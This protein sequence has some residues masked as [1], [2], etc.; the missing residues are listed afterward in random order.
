M[1]ATAAAEAAAA[2]VASLSDSIATAKAAMADFAWP[3]GPLFK[4]AYER[5]EKA[6]REMQSAHVYYPQVWP[7]PEPGSR[8]RRLAAVN[9]ECEA[10]S[11]AVAEMEAASAAADAPIRIQQEALEAAKITEAAEHAAMATASAAMATFDKL[12]I[13]EAASERERLEKIS[14][15]LTNADKKA[16][17]DA[18]RLEKITELAVKMSVTHCKRGK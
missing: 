18:R 6:I 11:T 4:A 9:A 17:N 2:K 10:A 13:A 8:E 3:N 5:K 16:A 12:Q 7:P 15:M 1:A 14:I